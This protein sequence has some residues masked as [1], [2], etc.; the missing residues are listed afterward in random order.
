[1]RLLN[2]T[3]LR[4]HWFNSPE[5]VE[6]GYAI[7]SHVWDAHEQTFQD[8]ERLHAEC[9]A[10]PDKHQEP[11]ERVSEK[12]RRSCELAN[13]QGFRW[14]WIDTCCIDK[15]SSAEL[16][17]A[18]NSM[19][20]YYALSEVSYAYLRDVEEVS[21]FSRSK[22]HRR[23]WTLQELIAPRCVHFLSKSWTFMGTKADFAKE[24]KSITGVPEAVL[25][26]SQPHTD[27]SITR[28]MRWAANRETTRLEDRAY[29]LLGI[30]DINMPTLYGE[31]SK[32]FQR[33]QEEIIK[34]H[35]DTTLFAWGETLTPP[36]DRPLISREDT[37]IPCGLLAR[38]PDDF[39]VFYY[40]EY[41][42]RGYERASDAVVRTPAILGRSINA[43]HS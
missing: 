21:D 34:K 11:R 7:L 26:L 31:G 5:E 33:L 18:I 2:T 14:L 8:V 1:M 35:Q 4:L 29:C 15:T 3:T 43:T 10:E 20:R 42:P 40:V 36:T 12:I 41:N 32:A 23:G 27:I 6:G 25:Q 38:S 28:R 19:Y 13:S 37:E 17:E 39:T 24:L 30:F 16:S 9:D 22:W